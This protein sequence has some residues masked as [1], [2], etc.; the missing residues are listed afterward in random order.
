LTNTR[1]LSQLLVG[2][3]LQ[4]RFYIVKNP[5]VDAIVLRSTTIIFVSKQKGKKKKKKKR[6]KKIAIA[7]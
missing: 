4:E 7:C 5:K 1:F 2:S 6:K 3:L